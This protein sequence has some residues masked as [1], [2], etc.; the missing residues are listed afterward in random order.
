VAAE[1]FARREERKRMEP[2]A[3]G[4][5]TILW[6]FFYFAKFKIANFWRGA[7]FTPHIVVRV[8]KT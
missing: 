8:D 1:L 3:P 4:G 7:I 5:K 2:V 6:A